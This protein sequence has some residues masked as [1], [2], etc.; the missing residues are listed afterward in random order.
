M[1]LRKY[2]TIKI[3]GTAERVIRAAEL[4]Q[5]PSILDDL[6][7]PIRILGNGSN[8]LIDDKGL[9]GTVVLMREDSSDT[10]LVDE[11]PNECLIEVGA[12]T[13]LPSLSKKFAR[14][15]W[16][17]TEYM[18]GVPGTMGGAVVQNAGANA[19]E[20]SSILEQV[21]VYNLETG[22][23]EERRAKDCELGYRTSIF[24]HEPHLLVWH[25]LIKLR[26]SS[27]LECQRKLDLNL[28]YRRGKTP[29][30]KPSLGSM[31]TRL[32]GLTAGEWIYPGELIERCGLKG[33]SFG[34]ARVSDLH[35]NYFINEGGATFEDVFN[36]ML[37]VEK[38]VFETTGLHLRREIEVWSDRIEE[39]T[40]VP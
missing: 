17:G 14:E 38:L 21:C 12:G 20:I 22:V 33:H 37:Y 23:W 34:G 27:A 29:Y 39:F 32:P 35:A 4:R 6:P 15:G 26:R 8:V 19:Q 24:K 40:K 30:A 5:Q 9:K 13:Y 18:V 31:Y 36:L 2:S 3:G 25:A 7:R 10:R 11:N 1:I 28:E 16:S